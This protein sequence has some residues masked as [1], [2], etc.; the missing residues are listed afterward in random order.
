MH[1]LSLFEWS[2]LSGVGRI[3][4]FFVHTQTTFQLSTVILHSWTQATIA[5]IG[6][7]FR[8]FQKADQ[9]LAVA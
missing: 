3:D 2:S 4:F 8:I 7:I 1:Y 9:I 5:L 6:H